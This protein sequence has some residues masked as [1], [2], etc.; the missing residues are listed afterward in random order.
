MAQ[1]SDARWKLGE[2][3]GSHV[4]DACLPTAGVVSDSRA[5]HVTKNPVRPE[6]AGKR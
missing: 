5:V 3:V 6:T 1:R 2:H 4:S